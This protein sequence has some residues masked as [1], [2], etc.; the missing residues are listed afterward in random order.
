MPGF[1]LGVL[2]LPG[3]PSLDGDRVVP[4][5]SP[6]G[7]ERHEAD[8]TVPEAVLKIPPQV[9][10]V[11]IRCHRRR[12]VKRDPYFAIGIASCLQL[13]ERAVEAL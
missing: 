11:A 6:Q 5:P 12:T 1:L 2:D 10:R 4:V 13:T 3:T 7:N 8:A 9:R